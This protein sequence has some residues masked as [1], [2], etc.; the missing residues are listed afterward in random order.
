MSRILPGSQYL[1][2][3]GIGDHGFRTFVS[4]EFPKCF[5]AMGGDMSARIAGF[6]GRRRAFALVKLLPFTRRFGSFS[7]F[8]LF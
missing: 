4:N 1:W 6:L 7:I 8:G 2:S 3:M 5:S